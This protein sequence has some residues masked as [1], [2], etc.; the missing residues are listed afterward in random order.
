MKENKWV[1]YSGYSRHMSGEKQ[2]FTKIDP[3]DGGHIKFG[4]NVT[5][6]VVGIGKV[7]K[8]FKFDHVLLVKGLKHNF[9]SVSQI[10]DNGCRVTFDS[11]SCIV[12]KVE[13][14]STILVGQRVDNIYIIDLDSPTNVNFSCLASFNDDSWT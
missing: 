3:L 8:D 4:N 14:N 2:I 6:K 10:C 11:I 1:V 13:D 9:L 5:G 7:G 12:I